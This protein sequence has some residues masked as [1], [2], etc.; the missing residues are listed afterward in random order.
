[1]NPGV[2]AICRVFER[3]PALKSAGRAVE[4]C[5]CRTRSRLAQQDRSK[6][7]LHFQPRRDMRHGWPRAEC[8][9]IDVIDGRQSARVKLAED[10]PLAQSFNAAKIE[11][12]G[13]LLQPSA[14][15]AL[16]AR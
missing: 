9:F 13:K 4:A 5:R 12:S 11:P 16:V 3:Y 15:E 1:M 2:R 6:Q 10:D 7:I 14:D 8:Y